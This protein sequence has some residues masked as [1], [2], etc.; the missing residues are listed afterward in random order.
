MIKE[1]ALKKNS[2][3]TPATATKSKSVPAVTNNTKTRS[4]P[5]AT[6]PVPVTESQPVKVVTKP[7]TTANRPVTKETKAR[8]SSVRTG[9]TKP[10]E[11]SKSRSTARPALS[12]ITTRPQ[13]I[14]VTID[15]KGPP[16]K[17]G[18][19]VLDRTKVLQQAA[20]P[21]SEVTK[22]ASITKEDL[23]LTPGR[24][25]DV[26]LTPGREDELLDEN[27]MDIQIA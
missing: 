11:I 23:L 10:R 20:K 9:P 2:K 26:L 14:V 15:N 13:S 19:P 7:R 6:K 1:K 3:P 17:S 25:D 4:K 21:T 18:I 22:P 8:T 24:D 5:S 16:V 12:S 27:L